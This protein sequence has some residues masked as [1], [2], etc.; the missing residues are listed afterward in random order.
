M[1][2]PQVKISEWQ[3]RADHLSDLE[4]TVNRAERGPFR[5]STLETRSA[6]ELTWNGRR[7]PLKVWYNL[8]LGTHSLNG[9]NGKLKWGTWHCLCRQGVVLGGGGRVNKLWDQN[10]APSIPVRVWSQRRCSP[11]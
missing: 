11:P 3:P 7:L 5:P 6:C 10:E 9:L 8:S 2:W 1:L 4:L